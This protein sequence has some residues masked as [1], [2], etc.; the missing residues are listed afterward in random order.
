MFIDEHVEFPGWPGLPERPVDDA[1]R[2]AFL[3]RMRVSNFDLAIQLQG[4]GRLSNDVVR[5]FGARRIA[6]HHPQ[7]RILLSTTEGLRPCPEQLHEI[8]R[9][10]APD[11]AAWCNPR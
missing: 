9:K 4:S 7:K 2:T 6:A 11:R 8:H 5:A 10:L 1:A 3:Q